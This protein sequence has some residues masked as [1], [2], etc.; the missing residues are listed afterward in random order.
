VLKW[1][2]SNDYEEHR[3]HGVRNLVINPELLSEI[4]AEDQKQ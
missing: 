1:L 4:K 2:E 3:L